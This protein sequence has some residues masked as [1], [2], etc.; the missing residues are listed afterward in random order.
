M[1]A[2]GEPVICFGGWQEHIVRGPN[3][4]KVQLVAMYCLQD[5]SGA[6]LKVDTGDLLSL[7]VGTAQAESKLCTFVAAVLSMLAWL[8]GCRQANPKPEKRGQSQSPESQSPSPWWQPAP[9]G[10]GWGLLCS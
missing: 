3:G 9:E 7:H 2:V 6:Q 1:V 4:Q 8:P 10:R 5:T